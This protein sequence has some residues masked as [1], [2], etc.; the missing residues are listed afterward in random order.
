MPKI[1][2]L[3][4]VAE[5][6]LAVTPASVSAGAVTPVAVDASGGF[7][8]AQFIVVLGAFGTNA[9]FDCEITESAT[10]GGAYTLITG[11][12]ITA[13]TAAKSGKLIIVDVPVNG[14]K[15]FLKLRGTVG[16]AAVVMSAICQ[17]Y[18]GTRRLS[19]TV[20]EDVAEEVVV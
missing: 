7:D 18:N 10:S 20:L 13:V 2:K 12:G 17:T 19:D 8:R 16:T 6:Q 11:S 1:E 3:S 15:P 5:P 9:G 4:Y 14:S